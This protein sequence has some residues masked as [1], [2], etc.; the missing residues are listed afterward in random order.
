LMLPTRK[1][2]AIQIADYFFFEALSFELRV[3]FE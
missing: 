1:T 3:Q 2:Q